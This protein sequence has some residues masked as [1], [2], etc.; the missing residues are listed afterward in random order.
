MPSISL[1]SPPN[2]ST[3]APL[4]AFTWE[5]LTDESP[6]L[7]PRLER[8]LPR[9]ISFAWS[10][11]EPE[12]DGLRYDL[13]V[14]ADGDFSRA[15]ALRD[16][17]KPAADLPH[18]FVDTRYF[19]KVIARRGEQMLDESPVWTFRTHPELPRW[20]LI[21]G[22]TNVRDVGGWR[23]G[24]GRRVR[25]GLIYRSA[26]LNTHLQ[27]TPEGAAILQDE[28]GI[29]TDLD[30]RGING[31]ENPQPALDPGRVN[32]V[33][34]KLVAYQE[35]FTERG[36][37]GILQAFQVLA[38]LAAYPVLVHC[39]GGADRTGTLVF[40]LNA[41]LGVELPDLAYDYE[42]TSYSVSA[43]RRSSSPEFQA[44]LEGLK[45]F[46]PAG[47]SLQAQVEAYLAS[48][49]VTAEQMALLRQ[50]LVES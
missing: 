10:S 25:Q 6:E 41:L 33:N 39:W 44:M 34:M 9:P 37:P 18:L 23:I 29:R 40:L 16:L 19:W 45:A 4:Q 43:L 5:G 13:L 1:I 22:T 17:I 35:I 3:S 20:I 38:D 7:T 27:V 30:L 24:D 26:E 50:L 31:D 42:L 2:G 14:A 46:A 11:S 28:L 8:S 48:L 32:W 49:G 15:R 21:P 12:G 47:A 36:Q